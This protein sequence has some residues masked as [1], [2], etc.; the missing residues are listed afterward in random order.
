MSQSKNVTRTYS[1]AFISDTH[2]I[3]T[4]NML[5]NL[6]LKYPQCS[7]SWLLKK[8]IVALVQYSL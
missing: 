5:Y 3:N 4:L 2:V 1:K 7:T 6:G 8:K